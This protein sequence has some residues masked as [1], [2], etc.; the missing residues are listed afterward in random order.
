MNWSVLATVIS[1]AAGIISGL[2]LMILT[3]IK[4]DIKAI[5]A[6]VDQ[7]DLRIEKLLERKN[8]CNQDYVGKV[9]YIRSTNSLEESMKKLTEG[10]AMLNGTIRVIEQMPQICGSIAK[11]IVREMKHD[12]I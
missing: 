9:E 10:V 1:A 6:R 3:S 12:K 8:L 2:I 5:S 7:Q 4:S 11:E